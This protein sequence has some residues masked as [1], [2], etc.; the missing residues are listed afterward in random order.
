[1]ISVILEPNRSTPDRFV[2]ITRYERRGNKLIKVRRVY[3]GPGHVA[4]VKEIPWA[5][6]VNPAKDWAPVYNGESGD[7]KKGHHA[8]P[9]TIKRDWLQLHMSLQYEREDMD[10]QAGGTL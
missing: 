2:A 6:T 7:G 5:R 10:I 8:R 9:F 4:S 1:V 3:D